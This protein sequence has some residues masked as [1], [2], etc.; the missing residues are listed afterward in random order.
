MNKTTALIIIFLLCI[1]IVYAIPLP[2]K[3]YF[4]TMHYVTGKITTATAKATFGYAPGANTEKKGFHLVILDNNGRELF[5]TYFSIPT[6]IEV[7][8]DKMNKWGGYIPQDDFD[9]IELIPYYPEG[10]TI[11]VSDPDGKLI[12]S[13][14]VT[15]F[16]LCNQNGRCE[17][18]EE[19]DICPEDCKQGEAGPIIK[20]LQGKPITPEEEIETFLH[21]C[22]IA[23][24][25]KELDCV[26]D[27]PAYCTQKCCSGKVKAGT[28]CPVP[29]KISA[30]WNLLGFSEKTKVRAVLGTLQPA[31][32][33]FKEGVWEKFTGEEFEMGAYFLDAA[34]DGTVNIPLSEQKPVSLRF[35][36]N[37]LRITKDTPLKDV[38][39]TIDNRGYTLGTAKHYIEKLYS[40]SNG[41]WKVHEI[42]SETILTAGKGYVLF[43]QEPLSQPSCRTDDT[44]VR[45]NNKEYIKAQ[46]DG[47][48]S[49]KGI[50]IGY[51]RVENQDVLYQTSN[52]LLE[53]KDVIRIPYETVKEGNGFLI[54][55]CR[56]QFPQSKYFRLP[57]PAMGP[58]T[59]Y[60][61]SNSGVARV[62]TNEKKTFAPTCTTAAGTV[63]EC[64]ALK[65]STNT[66][67]RLMVEADGRAATLENP[68]KTG[69]IASCYAPT[70]E[71]EWCCSM[72][73]IVLN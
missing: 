62:K 72:P 57:L 71:K 8:P 46:I 66:N 60:Y 50:I 68:I 48:F 39:V 6:L 24:Q 64:P 56:A 67:G 47:L 61:S 37:G 54:L 2:D 34:S 51:S 59:C 43:V 69:A 70:G 15:Q 28:S 32:F 14:D 38:P 36:W 21:P 52:E 41:Q 16:A 17:Q 12:K 35:G 29:M 19:H 65:W 5:F 3:S 10:K 22:V 58:V 1:D 30:G 20:L 11:E 53:R 55:P 44:R 27:P 42:T 13:I 7:F 9:H 49:V 4:V 31:I 18:R 23:S 25:G 40:F 33:T 45:Y 73:L 26:T 63:G